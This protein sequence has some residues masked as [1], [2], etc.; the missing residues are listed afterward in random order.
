MAFSNQLL[1]STAKA[2]STLLGG[3]YLGAHVRIGDGKFKAF[4]SPNVRKVWYKLLTRA[5]RYDLMDASALE[6]SFA[7]ADAIAEPPVLTPDG[8]SL[9]TPHPP[10]PWP[11]PRKFS[12]RLPCR[13]ALHTATS[14]MHLNIP[15]FVST[16]S[17]DPSA[18]PLLALF[19]RTF[20]CT[21][22]LSDVL[23]ALQRQLLRDYDLTNNSKYG[24]ANIDHLLN[25]YDGVPLK[26]F[27]LP[28]MDAMIVGNA[29]G[30]SGTDDSTFSAFVEDVLW[31]TYHG[32]EIV[33]RG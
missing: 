17:P 3:Q 4:G 16:D 33:Q 28:F 8:P 9:R 5:L 7:G 31:R 13:G 24:S 22:F 10:V 19:L 15:L 26:P 21:F 25:R 2:A 6:Q 32:W 12:P 27:L 29:W 14:L 18:D 1:V 11:L 20:P 30:I 23:P